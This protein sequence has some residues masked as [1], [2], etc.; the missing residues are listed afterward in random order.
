MGVAASLALA[1]ACLPAP[2]A[3]AAALVCSQSLPCSNLDCEI[4]T[5]GGFPPQPDP[6][7]EC[8]GPN[9]S[10]PEAET[11]PAGNETGGT[12]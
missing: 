7:L 4:L 12:P 10:P 3:E 11:A 2:P 1:V 9:S 8:L 5:I 6:H